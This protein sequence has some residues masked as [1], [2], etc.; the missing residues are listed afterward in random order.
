ML[1]KNLKK[2]III[3]KKLIKQDKI[4]INVKKIFK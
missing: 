2:K 4:V 3:L 1:L